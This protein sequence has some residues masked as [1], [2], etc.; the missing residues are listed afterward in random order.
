M[1]EFIGVGGA[2]MMNRDFGALLKANK[3]SLLEVELDPDHPER[4]KIPTILWKM[5]LTG[6]GWLPPVKGKPHQDVDV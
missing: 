5:C 1:S 6:M 2:S 3:G 4:Y